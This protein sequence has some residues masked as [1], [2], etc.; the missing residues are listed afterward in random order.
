MFQ[1]I[2]MVE[3]GFTSREID[4]E[5]IKF[6]RNAAQYLLHIKRTGPMDRRS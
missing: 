3:I 5:S 4:R 6:F 2:G 1:N